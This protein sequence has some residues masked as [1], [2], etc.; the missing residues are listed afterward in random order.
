MFDNEIEAAIILL[1]DIEDMVI[2]QH[3]SDEWVY[4]VRRSIR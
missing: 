1:R 4:M 2:Q 3:G